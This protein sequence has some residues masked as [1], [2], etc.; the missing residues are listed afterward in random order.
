MQESEEAITI[1]LY[2]KYFD[3]SKPYKSTLLGF[4]ETSGRTHLLMD[5]PNRSG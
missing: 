4:S 5:A 1:N 2:E 3:I